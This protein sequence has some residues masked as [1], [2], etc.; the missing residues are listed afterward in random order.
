M[1]RFLMK[2]KPSSDDLNL[3]VR[4]YTFI[5]QEGCEIRDDYLDYSL[6]LML[7]RPEFL[8]NRRSSAPSKKKP[9]N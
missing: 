6:K 2:S 7:G 3:L 5:L 1:S 9:L 4:P 8:W